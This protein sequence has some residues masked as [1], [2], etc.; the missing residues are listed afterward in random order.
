MNRRLQSARS[1][2]FICIGLF[3]FIILVLNSQNYNR[4][5]GESKI[6]HEMNEFTR[7]RNQQQQQQQQHVEFTIYPPSSPKWHKLLPNEITAANFTHITDAYLQHLQSLGPIPKKLHTSW[8]DKN[9]LQS[10]TKLVEMGLQSFKRLNPDWQIIIYNDD[11]IEQ[12]LK[13]TL[14]ATDYALIAPQH[15]IEKVDLWRLLVVYFEGGAYADI[16]RLFS[17]PM[18]EIIGTDVRLLLPTYYDINFTQDFLCSAKRNVLFKNA[19]QRN[20]SK[21]R[22]YAKQD[23]KYRNGSQ[24]G[25][26]L[27]MGPNQFWHACTES[28]F[29]LIITDGGDYPK[30]NKRVIE[31]IRRVINESKIIRTYREEWCD[32]IVFHTDAMDECKKIKKDQLWKETKMNKWESEMRA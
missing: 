21:R 32:T 29:D 22:I 20:L 28:L 10:R 14:S 18:A 7:K 6:D 9:V 27:E 15:I 16:D 2:V 11:E 12:Y 19:I 26:V 4:I 5:P 23:K 1:A 17:V 8:P 31:K 3:L 30:E 24:L 25:Y 13:R